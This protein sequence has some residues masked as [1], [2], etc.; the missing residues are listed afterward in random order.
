MLSWPPLQRYCSMPPVGACVVQND[1]SLEEIY[2]LRFRRYVLEQGKHYDGS[3]SN[4]G[5]LVDELDRNAVQ[6]AYVSNGRIGAALRMSFLGHMS[7]GGYLDQLGVVL[8]DRYPE[9]L[10]I[11]SRFI[12]EESVASLRSM[13]S[14]FRL[15]YRIGLESGARFSALST[16]ESL[17][18][19]FTT[20]GYRKTRDE[21][22]HPV[23]GPQVVMV[24]D[25]NDADHL[26]AIR[27]PLFPVL[28]KWKRDL[29][30][31]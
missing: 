24:L 16:R 12:M 15:A 8:A 6:L 18:V 19:H 25:L 22:E 10:I 26:E 2:R 3:D 29:Q 31:D 14:L 23:T 5:R 4:N 13:V 9:N 20:F 30:R 21:F 17:V 28:L 11:C 1:L 7:P 27:S